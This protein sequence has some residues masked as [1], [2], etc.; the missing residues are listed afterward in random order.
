MEFIIFSL[1]L[2][3]IF[4]SIQ[5]WFSWKHVN[6]KELKLG[7][8]VD[9]PFF[10]RIWIYVFLFSISF[11]IHEFL[12]GT[13]LPS[14][15]IYFELFELIGFTSIVLFAYEWYIVLKQSAHKKSLP[16]ELTETERRTDTNLKN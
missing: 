4:L 8:F 11:I 16:Q 2:I 9:E 13:N 14:A 10:K 12:E 5:I 1:Y 7:I 15:M 6:K 3:F